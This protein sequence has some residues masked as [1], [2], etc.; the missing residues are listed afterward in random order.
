MIS[1]QYEYL[2]DSDFLRYVDSQHLQEISVKITVLDW[3]E[4]PVQE[5]QGLVSNGTLN[6]NGDSAIRRTCNLTMIVKET[7]AFGM[8]KLKSLI[9][10]NK[11][12]RVDIGYINS[13]PYYTDYNMIWFPLG[14]FV[15]INPSFSHS[16][17]GITIS[18]QLKDKMCLLNGEC[19]GV[20]SAATQFDEHETISPDGE[21]IIEK[22]TIY[23][24]IQ[25]LVNHFG[26]EQLN[27]IVI[28][29]IEPRVKQ[30]MKWIG[31]NALYEY[32]DKVLSTELR[33]GKEP[34]VIYESGEDIGFI[35]VDFYYPGELTANAG[36]SVVT[37]LD[38]IKN[39]LGNF[40]YYYD[41]YGNFIFQEKKNYLNTSHSTAIVNQMNNND[42]LIDMANGKSVYEFNDANLITSFSNSPQ[43]SMI[44]NDFVVWG[45]RESATGLKLPL[46]FHLAIDKKPEIGNTYPDIVFWKDPETEII[47]AKK[48]QP[49]TAAM[50]FPG[51]VYVDENDNYYIWNNKEY[52]QL[53]SSEY[54]VKDITT[55]DWRDELYFQGVNAESLGLDTNYYYIELVNEW[56]KQYQNKEEGNLSSNQDRDF[57]KQAL[58]YPGD[59]D[60]FLDFID[61]NSPIGEFSV[62]NIGRRTK[63]INDDKINCV[64]EAEIPD[65]ILIESGTDATQTDKDEANAQGQKFIQVSSA[66]YSNLAVGGTQNSAYNM[67]RELLYEYTSYNESIQIQ[68]L[69]IYHLEPNTRITVN[70]IESD[71]HGDYIMKSISLP[72]GVSG[73]M[74][75]SATRALERI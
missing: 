19:G 60:F 10:L 71:I 29:D 74:S 21:Y 14:T 6:L 3:E 59:L 57:T 53:E 51:V 28:S 17:S 43:Y 49:K 55:T 52:K 54:Y 75:I 67:I 35:Y 50:G 1:K 58:N 22:P 34:T 72:L 40:E 9:S 4:N 12:I 32:E 11:K 24:I 26:G 73:T 7:E 56:P 41:I 64:F 39:T 69:P 16:L 38:K 44:K 45:I 46:R 42:Y 20:I 68:C 30:V 36:D 13:T 65:R 33:E 2:K 15:I 31:A 23:Q 25:E 63:V 70:D 5:I 27:K 37:I 47:K 61:S 18:L 8:A 62:Q 48:A 66:V